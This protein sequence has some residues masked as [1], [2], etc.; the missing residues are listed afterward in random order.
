MQTLSHNS[1][2]FKTTSNVTKDEIV[3]KGACEW[4][5]IPTPKQHENTKT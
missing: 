3:T 2:D 1:Y 4:T 5:I